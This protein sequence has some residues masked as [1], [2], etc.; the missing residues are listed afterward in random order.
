MRS[1]GVQIGDLLGGVWQYDNI[2]VWEQVGSAEFVRRVKGLY[3]SYVYMHY[4][5]DDSSPTQ[6]KIWR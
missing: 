2:N 6:I 3:G 4:F 5:D 1:V